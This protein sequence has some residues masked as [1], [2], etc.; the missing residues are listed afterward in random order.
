MDAL[1]CGIVSADR[2]GRVRYLNATAERLTGWPL[3]AARGRMAYSVVHLNDAQ[4]ATVQSVLERALQKD[5]ELTV[6]SAWLRAR[7]GRRRP[8]E[9]QAC[10][11]RDGSAAIDG[12]VMLCR[13]A[14]RH[15]AELD[16]LQREV[17]L[18]QAI[19]TQLVE[20]VLVDRKSVVEGKRRSGR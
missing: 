9:L 11:L 6:Q 13:D 16:R 17:R 20:G 3:A 7:D 12:V 1:D 5:A 15:D 19:V 10:L 2:E 4:G 14:T 8:V 18:A